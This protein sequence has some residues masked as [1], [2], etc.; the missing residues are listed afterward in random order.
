MCSQQA[1]VTFYR[2]LSTE[3]NSIMPQ[4][5]IEM[6]WELNRWRNRHP[7]IIFQHSLSVFDSSRRPDSS[8]LGHLFWVVK[9]KKISQR[10]FYFFSFQKY[11]FFLHSSL[12]LSVRVRLKE[13]FSFLQTPGKRKDTSLN[14]V[15]VRCL[16]WRS[17]ELLIAAHTTAWGESF[18]H[19]VCLSF[20]RN[21][22]SQTPTLLLV[23]NSL[24]WR[25][26]IRRSMKSRTSNNLTFCFI[27]S[28]MMFVF[29]NKSQ[30]CQ[31]YK[32]LSS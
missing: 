4:L 14:P 19:L 10:S 6:E 11:D 15:G 8:L 20:S 30:I 21:M 27:Y 2:P 3:S 16:K 7:R 26:T 12:S 1:M 24:S 18:S 29:D 28:R 22:F 31:M 32:D 13:G 9:K 23:Q 17:H 25:K 5:W